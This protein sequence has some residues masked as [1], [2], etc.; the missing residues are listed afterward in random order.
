MACLVICTRWG[1]M[2]D[3]SFGAP[4]WKKIRITAD[5]VRLYHHTLRHLKHE[6]ITGRILQRVRKKVSLGKAPDSPKN[7]HGRLS[8][9]SSF[10]KLASDSIKRENLTQGQ[11]FFLNEWRDLGES[12]NWQ[13]AAPLL[14]QFNLHYFNFIHVL[15][16]KDQQSLCRE[17]IE[18]NPPGGQPGWHP[19]PTSLRLV[20]WCKAGVEDTVI[21][22]SLY[23]QAGYLYRN[24]EKHLLGNHLLENARA[25]VFVGRF[26]EGQGEADAWLKKGLK[27]YREQTPEQILSDGGHFERSPMY[28]ALM[29]EGYVDVLNL[30]P[31]EH[32]DREWL[33]SVVARM[34]DYLRSLTHPNGEIVL[35][36]DATQEIALPTHRL[37]KYVREV[38][39]YSPVKKWA[40]PETGHFVHRSDDIF[41]AI[42][43]GP[44]GPDYLP[45]HAHADIFTYEL[46]V[47]GSQFVVD[48][49]VYDYEAGSMRD[50]VRSTEAH[51]TVCI[52]GVDQA[53]C[54]AAFRVARRYTP[55][56]VSFTQQADRS[57]FEGT[58]KGYAHLIGDQIEHLR[59]ITVN[60]GERRI[61]VEDYVTGYGQHIVRSRIHLHPDAHIQRKGETI[62]LQRGGQSIQLSIIDSQVRV[63]KG[64][65]CPEFGV[66]KKR[67]VIVLEAAGSLPTHLGYVIRY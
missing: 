34:A 21:Q 24:L 11:F 63:E 51:N 5:R 46:S 28:H 66:R 30:L 50:Y 60:T 48:T 37:L 2:L 14:W 15:D 25:L 36:N 20:N 13:P 29:L 10:P 35:F 38:T 61:I 64:W 12:V 42:D 17:W 3:R 41:L 32:D 26:F 16:A 44:V 52:D 33:T 39:G 23:Q 65:Y 8:S 6:Q 47:G 53:E 4:F 55:R 58:F 45:A 31:V 7:L 1:S 40:F 62:L 49:G 59:R 27:I 19:F 9:K 22:E 18:A 43:G 57:V 56:E 54:W 67:D